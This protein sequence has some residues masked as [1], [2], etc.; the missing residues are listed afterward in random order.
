MVRKKAM[1]RRKICETKMKMKKTVKT[2]GERRTR[3]KKRKKSSVKR[4]S[5]MRS[6]GK[7]SSKMMTSLRMRMTRS[8]C[9]ARVGGG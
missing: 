7:T 6:L 5:E 1:M 3:K 4:S 8:S 2:G 9:L